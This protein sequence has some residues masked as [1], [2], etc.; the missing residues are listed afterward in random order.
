MPSWYKRRAQILTICLLLPVTIGVVLAIVLFPSNKSEPGPDRNLAEHA[1]QQPTGRRV[2]ARL[3]Q[4]AVQSAVDVDATFGSLEGHVCSAATGRGIQSAEVVLE[5]DG[6]VSSAYTDSAGRFLFQAF[7]KG[8][9]ELRTVT[10]DGFVPFEPK[11]SFQEEVVEF[12]AVPQQR[13]TG[14]TIFLEPLVALSGVVLDTA[15]NTVPDAE[16]VVVERKE[17]EEVA[18]DETRVVTDERGEFLLQWRRSARLRAKHAELGTGAAWADGPDK[19]IEIV[20]GLNNHDAR[21]Q[22]ELTGWVRDEDGE[23]V[24][25]ARVY[26]YRRGTGGPFF[27]ETSEDGRF[28]VPVIQGVTFRIAASHPEYERGEVEVEATHGGEI[29]I[30]LIVLK[31]GSVVRGRVTDADTGRP[32][33]AFVVHV[34]PLKSVPVKDP[35][36]RFEV[37]GM[38]PGQA[39]IELQAQGYL[40]AKK[41]VMVEAESADLDFA[42]ERGVRV[43]GVVV[44]KGGEPIAGAQVSYGWG[45]SRRFSTTDV[46]GEFELYGIPPG[47][48]T[49]EASAEGFH[50][51]QTT[52]DAVD[53]REVGPLTIELEPTE[54]ATPRTEFTGIGAQI[55]SR[56]DEVFVFDSLLRGGAAAAG[57]ERGDEILRIDGRSTA[58]M[59][60]Q[61]AIELIRGP[62]GTTVR[63]R[64]HRETTDVVEEVEIERRRIRF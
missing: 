51:M 8:R 2:R 61:D 37:R 38:S 39:E 64:V 13:V 40:P 6:T 49:V 27:T 60:V 52:A 21:T 10:A 23:A 11:H 48:H 7:E 46:G 59:D 1:A 57:L 55:S 36:G 47:R 34:G 15:G 58:G 31:M 18:R 50:K 12:D 16:V 43:F 5:H 9:F 63:L 45:E 62:E 14:L 19:R 20:V 22:T 44:A 4:Q 53:A 26:V 25:R 42:L 32:V 35:S 17:G 33:T 28:S 41:T 30:V 29:E 56:D 24:A 54:G 3:I